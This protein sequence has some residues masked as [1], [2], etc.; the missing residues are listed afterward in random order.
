MDLSSADDDEI[1]WASLDPLGGTQA[2]AAR[3]FASMH[4]KWDFYLDAAKHMQ[5]LEEE[6]ARHKTAHPTWYR[7]AKLRWRNAGK[8][9]R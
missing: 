6:V 5:E 3:G 7:R 8:R 4:E 2:H 9:A 1:S